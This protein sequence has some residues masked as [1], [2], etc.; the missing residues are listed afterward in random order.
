ML[1]S[2][3]KSRI[4]TDP[5]KMWSLV[6]LSFCLFNAVRSQCTIN[7]KTD[8]TF[9]EPVFLKNGNLWI[10]SSGQLVWAIGESN[11]VACPKNNVVNTLLDKAL[12]TCVGGSTFLLNGLPVNVSSIVCTKAVTGD[13]QSTS[14]GCGNGGTIRNI[15]F[16]VSGI[17]FVKHFSVCY[18]AQTAS[19]IYTKHTING[20]SIS[21]SIV[22]SYRPSFKVTGV[23]STVLVDTSYT[24]KS[25]QTRLAELLGSST[26]AAKFVNTVSYL[27]R[28]H[29]TPDA[30]GIFR[31]WQWDTYFYVNVA[32]Q[33]QKVN[34][35]NWLIVEKIARNIAD[36]LQNDVTV[37]TG[38]F[39]TLTLPHANGTQVPI[40]LS[41]NGITVPKWTWK[42][43][44]SPS[45]N[46]AI[47]FVTSNDPYRT[48]IAP[49]ELLC[50]DICREYGWYNDSFD[51]LAKGFTYCCSVQSLLAKVDSV[52]IEAIAANV[53]PF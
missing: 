51:T 29:M 16:D 6:V 2:V 4:G 14:E 11:V 21:A 53:L 27:A 9:P 20:D 25:Q 23:P 10:P 24:I 17:G 1:K 37:Y 28:G 47:A 38:T 48:S 31:T 18:N 34:A 12:I 42:V 30:D 22:E 13:H 43:I 19:A 46:A 49:G 15:G 36:R 40:T 8:L 3:S 50:S 5:F 7:V 44:K 35:G 39:D 32:P 45:A 33:W 52:P 41:A 26:Q